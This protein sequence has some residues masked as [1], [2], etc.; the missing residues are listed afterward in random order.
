[1]THTTLGELI[2]VLYDEFLELYGDE[3][4]AAVAVSAT[5]N[6]LLASRSAPEAEVAAR[7][8]A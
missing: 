7:D 5:L 3:E 6:D 8:A 1:M 2:T 4:L